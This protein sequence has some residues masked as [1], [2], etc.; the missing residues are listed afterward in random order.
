MATD[1]HPY[2]AELAEAATDVT[3]AQLEA[4]EART[5]F[6]QHLDALIADLQVWQRQ[7][8][9]FGTIPPASPYLTDQAA[10]VADL[11]QAAE[12]AV[13]RVRSAEEH[14]ADLLEQW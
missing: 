4:D 12:S 7:V 3:R 9:D 5:V 10:T 13:F 1:Q 8:H 14:H 6:A 11:R 2:A